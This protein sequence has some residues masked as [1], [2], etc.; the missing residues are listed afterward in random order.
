M[1]KNVLKTTATVL[2]TVLL[3]VLLWQS[4]E[5]LVYLVFSLVFAAA[6]RPLDTM[7]AGKPKRVRFFI[8]AGV[9]AALGGLVFLLYLL[10][11]GLGRELQLLVDT[12]SHLKSWQL[13]VWLTQFSFIKTL[14][15]LMPAPGDLFN[16]L[17]AKGGQ[18]MLPFLQKLTQDTMGV[19][20]GAFVV[21]FLGLYWLSSQDH[22]ERLWLSLL[23]N[24]QRRKA[25][26]I[27]HAIETSLGVYGRGLF[28][29]VA[30]TWAVLGVG[31]YFL[32]SPYPVFLGLLISLVSVLPIVG[33]FVALLVAILIGLFSSIRFTPI[34][35]LFVLAVLI[36]IRVWV[37]PR[38]YQKARENALVNL[39]I[40][41]VIVD[42]FGLAWLLIAPPI[43]NVL[44]ILWKNLVERAPRKA[45]SLR[46]QALLERR[47]A[48][49][50][51]LVSL[52]EPPS[53]A[54]AQAL[55]KLDELINQA[56][57]FL[58]GEEI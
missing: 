54:V 24:A 53:P 41:L 29:Q 34:M 51:S 35:L 16:A 22:F 55:S 2:L 27:W 14:L 19:L 11:D 36:I 25:R 6:L 30:L 46:Y 21:I 45:P 15:D 5:I 17:T 23:P 39:V 1:N 10:G 31:L 47:Q 26:E 48:L 52:K 28:A 9:L 57:P 4:R 58:S 43:A 49:A 32:R 7:A 12:M 13:P 3:I 50:Q 18:A 37:K 8:L 44:Q 20:S 38:L 42:A 40:M 56:E 33:I